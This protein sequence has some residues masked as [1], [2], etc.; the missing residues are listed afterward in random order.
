[1][2][3]S[4]TIRILQ[5]I[6]SDILIVYLKFII[7]KISQFQSFK[8]LEHFTIL[9]MTFAKINYTS[10]IRNTSKMDTGV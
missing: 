4:H 2:Y 10:V 7:R 9:S 5:L 1:M 6:K 8:P 3:S